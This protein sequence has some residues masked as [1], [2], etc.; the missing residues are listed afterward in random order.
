MTVNAGAVGAGSIADDRVGKVCG[1]VTCG[2]RAMPTK[3]MPSIA[4]GS[5]T[6]VAATVAVAS[7]VVTPSRV[8]AAM[9]PPRSTHATTSA[10]RP[11]VAVS[12]SRE[13]LR[14]VVGSPAAYARGAVMRTDGSADWHRTERTVCDATLPAASSVCTS[15][16]NGAPPSGHVTSTQVSIVAVAGTVAQ[17]TLAAGDAPA[18]LA[19]SVRPAASL[20]AHTWN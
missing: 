18:T 10:W 19:Q 16:L 8:S 15:T 20:C 13:A 1:S 4:Q 14:I 2:K 6:L 17:P 11:G 7:G 9:P 3:P 12:M 5:P